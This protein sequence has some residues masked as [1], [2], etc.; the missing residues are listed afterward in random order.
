MLK[1]LL[2]HIDEHRCKDVCGEAERANHKVHYGRL[3]LVSNL[4]CVSCGLTY[5]VFVR[6]RRTSNEGFANVYC[7]SSEK[8]DPGV[9]HAHRGKLPDKH[10]N[11]MLKGRSAL[12]A[13]NGLL[14]AQHFRVCETCIE[15]FFRR[16]VV[17]DGLGLYRS[18]D[19]P[20][21]TKETADEKRTCNPDGVR[22][23]GPGHTC[24]CSSCTEA[25][26]QRSEAVKGLGVS[27]HT[28]TCTDRNSSVFS[29]FHCLIKG[30]RISRSPCAARIS[31]SGRHVYSLKVRR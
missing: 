31:C 15:I 22:G 17:K 13:Q 12:V 19:G 4:L 9:G 21:R 23:F 16:Q 29:T 7:K 11:P 3:Q 26:L 5:L 1:V 24:Q 20:Y 30:I 18:N 28:D 25:G 8:S 2:T 14:Y 27:K 6:P 10:H